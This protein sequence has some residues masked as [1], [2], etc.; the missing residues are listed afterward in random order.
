MIG[1]PRTIDHTHARYIT[2]TYRPPPGTLRDQPGTRFNKKRAETASIFISSGSVSQLD[3]L[4]LLLA[5][6]LVDSSV[7][8]MFLFVF[9]YV[10]GSILRVPID[11]HGYTLIIFMRRIHN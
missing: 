2:P 10:L 8:R 3:T 1:Q 11:K 7:S 6:S 4:S 9:I 5:Y